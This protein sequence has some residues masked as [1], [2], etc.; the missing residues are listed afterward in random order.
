MTVRVAAIGMSHWH[1]LW[2]AAYLRHLSK[3]DMVEIV[4]IQDPD[5]KV[6]E[7]RASEVGGPPVFTDYKE[8][9]ENAKPDFVLALGRHDTM[10]K[11]ALDLIDLGYPFIMEKP[12]GHNAEETR[13]VAEKAAQ[14]DHFVAA[15]LSQRYIPFTLQ[16]KKMLAEDA[17]GAIS[18]FY[19]R[20]NRPSSE[21]YPA[22]NCDWML[23]P[24]IANGGCLR[25]LGAHGL[26]VMLYLL[27]R[28]FEVTGAQLGYNAFGEAVEDYATVTLESE[29]GILATIEV[30][31]LYPIDGTDGE[32]K[33]SGR[34]ALLVQ[35]ISD[36]PGEMHLI[37]KDGAQVLPGGTDENPFAIVLRDTLEAW[38]RGDPPPINAMDVYRSVQ[39]IDDAYKAA[40]AS[41]GF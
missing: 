16:A 22:W 15:P 10:G 11:I 29:D 12:M 33:L 5:R 9:L 34:E 31:N 1:S 20:M 41:Y 6:A 24:K 32:W 38:Q 35:K 40:G 30:G 19:Y 21:R 3:L 39:L 14:Q 26:D 36:A 37:T 27:E 23:D 18:H 4:G 2:D 25:N 8:M 28:E 17:F 7:H 13:R